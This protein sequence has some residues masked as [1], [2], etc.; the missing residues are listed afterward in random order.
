MTQPEEIKKM[1][2]ENTKETGEGTVKE[3]TPTGN[4]TRTAT[5]ILPKQSGEH[6]LREGKIKTGWL[7]CRITAKR[8]I[9]FCSNCLKTG[10][11]NQ[12]SE[13]ARQTEKQCHKCTETGHEASDCTNEPRCKN[14]NKDC[15]Q[16]T[17]YDC[18]VS[19]LHYG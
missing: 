11:M 12:L 8:L 9:P 19:W 2:R 7:S 15:H 4:G 14:C 16:A 6:L 10:H 18:P 17:S 1:I 13:E 3:L 5:V